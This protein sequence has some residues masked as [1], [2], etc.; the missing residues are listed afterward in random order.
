VFE[1][2]IDI[3][4]TNDAYEF[5]IDTSFTN[6]TSIFKEGNHLSNVSYSIKCRSTVNR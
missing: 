3:K 6:D 4:N 2:D 1:S 5:D